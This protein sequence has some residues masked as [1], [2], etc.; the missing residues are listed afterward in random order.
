M[1]H[2]MWNAVSAAT[3]YDVSM[4][5]MLI[6]GITVGIVTVLLIVDALRHARAGH[7]RRHITKESHLS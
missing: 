1:T 6:V 2:R 7:E 3:M 5:T 4:F